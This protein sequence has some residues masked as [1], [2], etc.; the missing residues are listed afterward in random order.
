MRGYLRIGGLNLIKIELKDNLFY[1]LIMNLMENYVI[2][3][4][5]SLA[6]N[7]KYSP[8]VCLQLDMKYLVEIVQTQLFATDRVSIRLCLLHLNRP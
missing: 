3:N 7:Y 8:L 2:N 6:F 4:N 1:Q 5:V